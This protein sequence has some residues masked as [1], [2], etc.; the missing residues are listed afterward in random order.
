MGF[1]SFFK[2]KQWRC[3]NCKSDD[4]KFQIM[5]IITE[6]DIPAHT[7]YRDDQFEDYSKTKYKIVRCPQCGKYAVVG[8]FPPLCS[9]CHN[10]CRNVYRT[11][12][13]DR[14]GARMWAYCTLPSGL[15]F[16]YCCNDF[17]K[18]DIGYYEELTTYN[19][20]GH[21]VFAGKQRVTLLPTL[22]PWEITLE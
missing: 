21:E 10:E 11:G 22:S 12:A 6:V 13:V 7:E 14:T 2:K 1:F 3:R 8:P 15:Y 16:P 4:G 20:S 18:D 5:M 9:R 17:H 19:A